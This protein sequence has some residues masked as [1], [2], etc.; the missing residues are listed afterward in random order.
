MS[1]RRLFAARGTC[2]T[3][4]TL[5]GMPTA[6]SHKRTEQPRSS[7]RTAVAVALAREGLTQRDLARR[8][9]MPDTTLSGY[10]CG[11]HRSPPDLAR[12]I[13]SALGLRAGELGA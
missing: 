7:F 2:G 8:L 11:A 10:L 4:A 12:R 13:E 3:V 5:A 6:T 9:Q 1:R